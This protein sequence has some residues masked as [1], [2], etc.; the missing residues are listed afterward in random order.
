MIYEFN[1][2]FPK[3]HPTAF[4]AEQSIIVGDVEI[5]EHSSIWFYTVARGDVNFIR[6]GNKTNIQDN[7]VLHVTTNINPLIIG[8]EVTVGHRAIIHGCEIRDRVLVGMGSVVLDGAVINCDSMIAA[9]SVIPPGFE[10]PSKKLAM[11]IPAKIKR[12]LTDDEIE[13]IRNSSNNYVKN[14]KN[15]LIQL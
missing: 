9:G 1:G 15:Y 7:S 3:I 12:D 6:I 13:N 11:G 8:D 5:G 10:L 14:S 4:I 2:T